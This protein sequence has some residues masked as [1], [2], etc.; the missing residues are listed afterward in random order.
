MFYNLA[1]IQEKFR[2]F[3]NALKITTK[4]S[5]NVLVILK[6]A[7]LKEVLSD[8]Q[9]WTQSFQILTCT[10]VTQ[11]DGGISGD[12]WKCEDGNFHR[13]LL[14]IQRAED[15]SVRDNLSM[16]LQIIAR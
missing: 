6:N 8:Y 11:N 13:P 10:I 3:S 15:H 14:I 16:A 2:K 9:K 4:I 12:G 5:S 7:R 1:M